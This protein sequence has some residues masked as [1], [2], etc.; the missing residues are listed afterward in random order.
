MMAARLAVLRSVSCLLPGMSTLLVVRYTPGPTRISSPLAAA[1][2]A[3]WMFV[4]A[5]DQL[6]YGAAGAALDTFT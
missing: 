6:V 2:M 3:A 4:A 5:I 1:L